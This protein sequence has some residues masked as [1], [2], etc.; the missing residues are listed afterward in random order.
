VLL[1]FHRHAALNNLDTFDDFEKRVE[2]TLVLSRR[3][4]R[5]HALPTYGMLTS[6]LGK[7]DEPAR[8]LLADGY[9]RGRRCYGMV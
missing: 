1:D 8:A 5:H 2:L 6:Q 3:K 4:N 9:P 7:P